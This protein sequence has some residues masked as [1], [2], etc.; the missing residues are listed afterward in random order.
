LLSFFNFQVKIWFQ[1][2]RMKWRNS[3]ERELLAS[4]GSR[5]QTLPNKNNPN[6]DLSDAK[7]DRQS[8]ISPPSSPLEIATQAARNQQQQLSQQH[9]QQQQQQQLSQ[10]PISNLLASA[11]AI[12]NKFQ[13]NCLQTL[14]QKFDIHHQSKAGQDFKYE[15]DDIP[16]NI[17]D[18]P[19]CQPPQRQIFNQFFDRN[20][21]NNKFIS[22]PHPSEDIKMNLYYDEYDSNSDSEEEIN[23]T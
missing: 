9:Q 2:R 4:G 5:D 22:N 15:F 13:T 6:P 11:K 14:K 7:C 3:K 20:D 12:E 21:N 23:V 16:A 10:S 1:N 8:S 19:P 18:P 17:R